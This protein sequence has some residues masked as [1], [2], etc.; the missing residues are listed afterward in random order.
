MPGCRRAMERCVRSMKVRAASLAWAT[1]AGRHVPGREN[2]MS[3]HAQTCPVCGPISRPRGTHRA[4]HAPADSSMVLRRLEIA[5]RSPGQC[6][7]D[8]SRVLS[9]KDSITHMESLQTHMPA[10]RDLMYVEYR[11]TT[12]KEPVRRCHPDIIGRVGIMLAFV[13]SFSETAVLTR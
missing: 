11:A 8:D 10:L 3:C 13:Q 5:A 6:P 7:S 2:D 12:H 4:L 9:P 1:S